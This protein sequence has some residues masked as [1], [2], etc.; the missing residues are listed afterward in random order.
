MLAETAKKIN[1]SIKSESE[2]L[3]ALPLQREIADDAPKAIKP[4]R[5]ANLKTRNG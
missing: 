2:H 3:K 4:L 1:K 5:K